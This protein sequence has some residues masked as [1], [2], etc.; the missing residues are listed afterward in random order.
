[1]TRRDPRQ[2]VST[3][4]LQTLWIDQKGGLTAKEKDGYSMPLYSA[5]DVVNLLKREHRAVVRKVKHDATFVRAKDRGNNLDW[6]TGYSAAL[7][8][9][10]DWLDQ[11][12]R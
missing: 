9:L 6:Q 3:P 7:T 11:R 4:H 12:G 8:D 1:M 5:V 10:L 2:F